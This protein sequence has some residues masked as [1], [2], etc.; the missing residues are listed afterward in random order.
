MVI[1]YVMMINNLLVL[2]VAFVVLLHDILL[3][4]WKKELL[5]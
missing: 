5:D 1:G 4:N 2:L 3:I